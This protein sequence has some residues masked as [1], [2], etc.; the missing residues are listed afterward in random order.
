MP[1]AQSK[2]K[3]IGYISSAYGGV[4]KILGLPYV[5]LHEVLVDSQNQPAALV[6]GFQPDYIEALLFAA[7]FDIAQPLFR[8]HRTFFAPVGEAVLGQ[9]FTGLG[10][11]FAGRDLAIG[12][13]MPVFAPAP[14]IIDR[15]PVTT[16]LNTGIKIIDT[17]LPLGRGQR[18]LIIGDRKLGKSTLAA[19]IVLNQ[20]QADKPVKCIYVICGQG[21]KKLKDLIKLFK[22]H[23]AFAYTAIVAATSAQPLAEQY[24]APFVGC[25]M[26]EYF[27]DQGQDAL[28]VYDDLSQH[29]KVYRDIALL[30]ERP[31]GRE[32]YPGDIFSLHAGLLERAGQLSAEKGG[33]SLTALPIIETQEGDITSFIP[34]NLISI[35][36]GQIYLERGLYQKKFLPAV[37]V[38]LSVSRVGSQ[39]QPPVLRQVIGGIRLALAQHKELQKLAQLETVV[40]KESQAKI[41]RGELILET[42]KQAKH[43]NITFA[44]QVVLFYVV[45]E[46]FFDDIST[47]QWLEFED[48][49]L[50]LLRHRHQPLLEKIKKAEALNDKIKA[51]IS[52]VI[53]DF[54]HKFLT[55]KA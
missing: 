10:Q 30:L 38:G 7:D 31:P 23:N 39:A 8:S 51:E 11:P 44:E 3:E 37:N 55:A 16:P 36:D 40:S 20:R 29:A 54:R 22:D 1:S 19:D 4:V 13:Q 48:L 26:A 2:T 5:F 6:I 24:L 49:F 27:R 33:G 28:I 47:Q 25:A 53:Y 17:T 15:R 21:Q 18:E 41:H 9:V 12:R 34:T 43:T 42:M 14:P 32:T 52:Q 35:T 50:R 45:E 46:G